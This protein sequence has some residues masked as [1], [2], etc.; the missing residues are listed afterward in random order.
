MSAKHA[1]PPRGLMPTPRSPQIQ[2]RFGRLFRSLQPAVFGNS[3]ADNLA[4][5]SKLGT[6]I[7]TP[8][9][10]ADP[11]PGKDDEE[12]GIPALYAIG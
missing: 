12:R 5:L 7:T 1:I 8:A 11:K 10:P 6:A 9:D 4:N 3:D 2:G